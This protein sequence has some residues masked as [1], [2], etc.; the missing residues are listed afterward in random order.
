MD[1]D[2]V[3]IVLG[4]WRSME[5]SA[6]AIGQHLYVRL[7]VTDP[8]L[9]AIL[10][11]ADMQANQ[12]SLMLMLGRLIAALDDPEA[13]VS[14]TGALGRRYAAYRIQPRH[15]DHFREALSEAIARE[16]GADFT[17]ERRRAW[18]EVSTLIISLLLRAMRHDVPALLRTNTHV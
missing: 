4:A 2:T 1:L 11:G 5:P 7:S 16:L 14:M 15:L 17:I 9:A 6:D 18:T 12:H 3:Q 13:L 10:G 8:A